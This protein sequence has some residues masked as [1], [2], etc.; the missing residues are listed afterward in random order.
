LPFCLAVL[1]R[2]IVHLA[3]H[4]VRT[5]FNSGGHRFLAVQ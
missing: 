3:D 2:I 5:S 1:C 4:G